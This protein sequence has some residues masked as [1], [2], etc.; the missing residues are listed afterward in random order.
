MCRSSGLPKGARRKRP[1]ALEAFEDVG[2]ADAV[3]ARADVVLS[4]CPPHA[5]RE[6]AGSV[7]GFEGIYVDAN[8]IAPA[9]ARDVLALFARGVDGGIV[10]APPRRAHDAAL[11]LRPRGAGGRGALRRHRGRRARR[12]RGDRRRVGSQG[13]L[14]RLVEGNGRDAPRDPSSSRGRRASR[15]RCW[16]NGRI[17]FR[18]CSQAR[19]RSAPP[20][21]PRA[22]AGSARWRRSR[23]RSPRT[24]CPDG[25]HRAAAEVFR[26]ATRRTGAEARGRA[27]LRRARL[28]RHLDRRPRRGAGRAEGDALCVHREQAG[29][30]VRDDARG[31]RRVP[32]ARSTPSRSELPAV[33]KI[34]LALRG[35]LRVVAEQLDVATVF[36]QEWRY[37]EGERRDEIVGRAS[38]LR[39]AD[40]RA[41]PRGPRAR[42]ATHRPRR[43]RPRR[44]SCSRP[45]TGP[46]PGCSPGGTP[47]SSPIAS[48]RS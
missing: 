5:A 40:P 21:T 14:R 16:P 26:M 39:G 29:P 20:P 13:H 35:H 38:P 6:V 7:A 18:S 23:P 43:R 1:A 17:R 15:A 12:L 33:E 24:T 28:P 45:P 48:L 42:R 8:A 19:E 47:T 30:A 34:R 37:L 3:A 46:T 31:S 22:G 4:I 10:G 9:T 27:A 44:C 36:V 11:P 25:F 2:T 41:L 32:R